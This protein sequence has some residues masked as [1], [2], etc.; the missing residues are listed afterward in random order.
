VLVAGKKQGW[1]AGSGRW[2]DW[3]DKT[4]WPGQ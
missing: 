4:A 1:Q 3:A 2:P